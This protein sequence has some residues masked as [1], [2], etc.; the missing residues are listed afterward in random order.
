[1]LYQY[2]NVGAVDPNYYGVLLINKDP[3][4]VKGSVDKDIVFTTTEQ[5]RSDIFDL[6]I[7]TSFNTITVDGDYRTYIS[8]GP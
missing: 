3:N 4:T 8:S 7:N 6:M 5:L 1:M 2:E